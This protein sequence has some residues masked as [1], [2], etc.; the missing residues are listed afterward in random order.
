MRAGGVFHDHLERASAGRFAVAQRP[1]P[2]FVAVHVI[3]WLDEKTGLSRH[4]H[5]RGSVAP[6]CV[7]AAASIIAAPNADTSGHLRR[8]IDFK[9]RVFNI[10]I[11]ASGDPA[12]LKPLRSRRSR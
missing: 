1:P 2:R 4:S 12:P 8:R 6:A 11:S 3:G 9:L 10:R 5:G 7:A